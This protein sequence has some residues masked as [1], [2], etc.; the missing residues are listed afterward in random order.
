MASHSLFFNRAF[1]IESWYEAPRE[2]AKSFGRLIAVDIEN[3][4]EVGTLPQG[5]HLVV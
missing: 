1:S 4:M 5:L 3:H 2:Q